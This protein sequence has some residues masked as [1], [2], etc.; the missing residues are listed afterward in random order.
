MNKKEIEV[1]S[2]SSCPFAQRTR[3]ALIEK[4]IEFSLTE[5]D[6]DNKPDWFLKLSPY[7]KVPVIRNGDYVVF[8]S[9]IINEYIEEIFPQ[10]PLLPQNPED[11]AAARVWIDFANV[12]FAPQIYKILLAQSEHLQGEH[13][14][15]LTDAILMM[16]H[17]GLAKRS[18][19][20]YWLG[21]NLSLVDLTFYPHLQ[22]F[23]ALQH[24]RNFGI[25]DEC[26]KLKEWLTKMEESYC[27][28]VTKMSEDKLIKSWAKYAF[29]TSTGTTA[30]D[31]REVN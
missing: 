6:L 2:S 17:Q 16:E 12:R 26:V 4:E 8:E 24:Y 30:D 13:A 5:I 20:P 23:C 15:K 11:R 25:P 27:V 18:G 1:I 22:R 21:D 29:N 19:G 10:K 9:S 14:R 7:G 31:M 3:M 28:Q